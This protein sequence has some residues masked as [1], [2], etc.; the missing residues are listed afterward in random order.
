MEEA[1]IRVRLY[2]REPGGRIY[3]DVWVGAKRDRTSCG[4]ADR[5]LAEAE[6]R[7]LARR[8]SDL[9]YAGHAGAVTF[10]QL[11]A[12]YRQHRFPLLSPGR[13][14]TAR[15]HLA[16]LERH[17]A[18]ER[19]VDGLTQHD[20]DAYVVARRRGALE[21]PD[22]RRT[23]HT[24]VGDGTIRNELALLL[25]VLAW[26][27]VFR[28]NGRRLLAVNPLHG[29]TLPREKNIKRPIA[30]ED[31]YRALLAVAD[32]AEPT[33]RFRLLLS[34]ARLTGRRVNA[35]CSL[36]ASDVLLAR[37]Q[38][39]IAIAD[40]GA[41]LEWA[42]KW[43]YGALR[44]RGEHDKRGYESV[45]P[46]SADARAALDAYLRAN[47][48]AGDV[49]LMPANRNRDRAPGLALAGRWMRAAEKLAKVPKLARGEWHIWRRLWA[50]ER[51]HLPVQDLAAVGGW[52]SL[53]VLRSIYQHADAAGMLS[54]VESPESGPKRRGRGTQK[55]QA[56]AK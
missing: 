43:P 12:L 39:T 2:E 45:V 13:Q 26:G 25:S 29:A 44:F 54:A 38:V 5:K 48:R 28:V 47:P 10:G 23:K 14:A 22:K 17:I 20:V 7:E 4:H 16:L 11:M 42:D 40:I 55:A 32:R 18:R 50:T 52:R 21:S 51:R 49:P 41:P 24:G 3:R 36:H 9:Q 15:G 19:A 56:N 35:L 34:L 1:G 8:L 46:L 53:S 6:S 27:L 30:T 31:R 37:E 33:G